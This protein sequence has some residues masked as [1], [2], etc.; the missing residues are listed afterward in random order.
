MLPCVQW[1]YAFKRDS[2]VH[3]VD[4]DGEVV[5]NPLNLAASQPR[6]TI[7]RNTTYS[8]ILPHALE[9]ITDI[10][11]RALFAFGRFPSPLVLEHE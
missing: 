11:V 9:L 2:R 3:L 5:F 7:E 8:Q 6:M 10:R 1:T 4:R